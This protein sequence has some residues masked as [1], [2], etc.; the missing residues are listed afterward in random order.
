MTKKKTTMSEPVK[1][2]R[3]YLSK[4]KEEREGKKT[5]EQKEEEEEEE[6]RIQIKEC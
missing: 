3:A 1:S 2:E 4:E 5:K 6:L